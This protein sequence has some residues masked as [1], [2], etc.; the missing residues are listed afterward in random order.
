M[1]HNKTQ[2]VRQVAYATLR[3][4]GGVRPQLFFVRA[5]RFKH[6]IIVS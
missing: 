5:G 2:N 1:I 3:K 4:V 6:S